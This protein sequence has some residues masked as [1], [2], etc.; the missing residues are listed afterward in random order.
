MT[1]KLVY[2]KSIISLFLIFLIGSCTK[3]KPVVSVDADAPLFSKI[4]STET[5]ISFENTSIESPQRNLGLYDY[6]YNGSGV[7]IGD[8]NNDGL[9]DIFFAGNDTSN[10]LY[11]NEG[12]FKFKDISEKAGIVSNNWSTGV[13]MVDI[14]GDGYLDIYVCNSGPD[15]D[16]KKLA[17]ALYINNGDLTFTESAG[18]Y[19]IADTSYSSQATFF[20]M[21]RDGDLD[22]FVMNHS[23]IGFAQSLRKWEEAL[24]EKDSE[25]REKSCS[26]LYSNNGNG[27]FTDITKEAG[28][29]LPGFGLGVAI[30]DFDENGFLDVYVANDYFVPDFLFFNLGGGKFIENIK[31]RASHSSFYG[32]GCDAADFNNDGLVDLAI[33]D[34]TP[35]DHYRGKTLMNRMNADMFSYLSDGK[36]FLPQYMFNTLNLNRGKGNFSEIA[37]LTEIAQTDWSWAVLFVDLDNDSWK[38]LVITNGF[39]RDTKDRDWANTL[40]ERFDTEG[41]SGKVVFDQIQKSKS[42]PIVNYLYKNLGS[43]SFADTSKEWGF[44]EPSF[45]QGVAYGDLDND[46]DLDIVINN[47]ESEAFVYRNNTV[48]Q[49]KN[50]YIQ[51]T[52][53]DG[54]SSARVLHSKIKVT[55]GGQTQLV[56]YSFVR[57]YISTMQ[58]MAHF[59]L[60]KV[61]KVD[62]VEFIWPDGKISIIEN[63][64]INKKHSIDRSKLVSAKPVSKNDLPPFIDLAPKIKGLTYVHK[65]N[66]YND[67]KVEVLLPQ[68]QST[69]GPCLSVGDV[70]LDGMDDFY[71][72]GAKGQPG[73]LYFQ[74]LENGFVSSFQDAFVNDGAFE[75]IGSLFLD[76]DKDGDLDLYV[77]SGGGG[78]V[79][80][81]SY[82][83][84]DRLYLNDGEGKFSRSKNTLPKIMA[85]TA[86][87]SANDWDNDGDMDL[88]V[89]GRTTPG[90]YPLPPDS[91]LLQ[92]ENG[93]FKDVT[94]QLAPDLR[95]IGM[96]T[97]SCWSDVDGD[98]RKDL[99]VVGEWMPL[100]IFL[101]TTNGFENV[102]ERFG[103][104]GDIGWW[105]SIDKG[106]FDNDGDEDFIIGNLGLNNKF[107]PS[108]DKPL[109]IFSN[110]FDKNGTL[111]IVLSKEYKGSLAPVRGKDCS[112]E[113]MPFLEKKFPLFSDFA[114]STLAD[115]YGA[116]N[117]NEALHYQAT[118][119]ASMYV[120]N[121]GN[122]S[123]E[124]KP[125]P[126]E[127]QISPVKDMVVWDFD[128]DG[129]LDL[130]IGGN[131]Y[132]TEVETP[133][134]DSGKGLFLKGRGDGT[135]IPILKLEESGIFMPENVKALGLVIV[136][137][138]KRPGVLVAN[139]NSSLNLFIWTK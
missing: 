54:Q 87:V 136:T 102:S 75:D 125:L 119:F 7:A 1:F 123:F 35:S 28:M 43:L 116:Q 41:V 59:G 128:Q 48:E 46:G 78:D 111:D 112:T 129:N 63:P 24:S 84:Q 12:D 14:N 94:T 8:L 120:E 55:A 42:T 29:Y 58:P 100:T 108:E 127:A 93:I 82:L 73:Q 139:N 18:K 34:M 137:G 22:L 26:T 17:N 74:E 64:E 76:V 135:F 107:H 44:D 15:A 118:N 47:L 10:K 13:V 106:D 40:Q 70:N 72:G 134:Y 104:L 57:G 121:K 83:L 96:V 79:S 31:A 6:F 101:N 61:E 37:Q 117:L 9:A 115:I 23:L 62:K 25:M 88:F 68:K 91:F 2:Y 3:E 77:S 16:N 27:S 32:M 95:K 97:S 5:G 67:F 52:L 114:S 60:G 92:N 71:V 113:Q 122:G 81:E 30:S 53:I 85:S 36:G 20:D 126:P 49:K 69:L 51:F 19:G 131:M 99:I 39:K 38:D 4:P 130:V 110:D 45:S 33:V 66:D 90:R 50:N 103:L 11:V 98:G 132:N 65:E 109:H 21:D 138:Q 56:E 124:M 133:A 80:E 105:Y 86:S 89:G